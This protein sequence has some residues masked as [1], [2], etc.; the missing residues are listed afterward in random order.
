MISIG[1]NE[2]QSLLNPVHKNHFEMAGQPKWKTHT[3]MS[4]KKM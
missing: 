3:H 4:P 1:K 2:F